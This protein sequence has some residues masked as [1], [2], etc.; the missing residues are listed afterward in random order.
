VFGCHA[1]LT[2]SSTPRCV[3]QH[4]VFNCPQQACWQLEHQAL[5]MQLVRQVET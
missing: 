3:A 4:A 5:A 1:T 2:C